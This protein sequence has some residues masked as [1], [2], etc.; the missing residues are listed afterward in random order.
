MTSYN[1]N[2]IREGYCGNCRDWTQ[3]PVGN[4]YRDG[5]IHV[6]SKQCDHCLLSPNRL[7]SGKRAAEIVSK[8]KDELGATFTCH[9]GNLIGCD[10][11]CRR[12]YDKF[13]K[14]DPI[15]QLAEAKGL[16]EFQD[17]IGL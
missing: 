14:N 11:I 3:K 17:P 5:K 6:M 2:D 7:V 9:K 1:P 15:L 12:W 13:A 8:T 4:T 10:A 16:I